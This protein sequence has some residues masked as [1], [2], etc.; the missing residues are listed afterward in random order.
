MSIYGNITPMTE[1]PDPPSY[2]TM[3]YSYLLYITSTGPCPTVTSPISKVMDLSYSYHPYITSTGP[4]RKGASPI[5]QV[6]DPVLQLQPLYKKN[7]DHDLPVHS[8]YHKYWTMPYRYNPHIISNGPCP[9]VTSSISQVLVPVLPV[10]PLYHKY[11]TLSHLYFHFI[12]STGR[13]PT[14]TSPKSQVLASV[15]Q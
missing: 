6:L 13:C 15:P 7:Q 11:W 8:L 4:C 12:T 3:S 9:T 2:W 5:S 10:Y 1:F 14:G